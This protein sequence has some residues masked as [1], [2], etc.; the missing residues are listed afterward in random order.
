MSNKFKILWLRHAS[1]AILAPALLA[2]CTMVEPA[3]VGNVSAAP[4]EEETLAEEPVDESD[5]GDVRPD[6][7][8]KR[9]DASACVPKCKGKSC[10]S[11]L[12]GGTCGTCATGQTCTGNACVPNYDAGSTDSGSPDAASADA[13]SS[14]ASS[15]CSARTCSASGTGAGECCAATP[16]CGGSSGCR[17]MRGS[18]NATC[19]DDAA[20]EAGLTCVSGRCRAACMPSCT[21]KQCGSDGCGGSC[22]TCAA[23]STCSAGAC[24]ARCVPDCTGRECG[25]DGCGGTCGSCGNRTCSGG[26]CSGCDPVNDTGCTAPNSCLVL[27]SESTTCALDG[28]GTRGSFCSATT[29]CAGAYGCFANQCRKICNKLTGA[30]CNAA[31]TCTGVTGWSRY[32]AC[33]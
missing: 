31:E 18:A 2:H 14:D 20:C 25:S 8:T 7:G 16:Y 23:T 33:R 3:P 27:A 10:G 9:P 30:G 22:G 21:G 4:P 32:G 12:C 1:A 26:T 13:A 11:D 15:S 24:V 28:S 17:A 5:V 6:A 19:M 29:A